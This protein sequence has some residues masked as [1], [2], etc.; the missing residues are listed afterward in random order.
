MS[1]L[2]SCR[3]DSELSKVQEHLR[4]EKAMK[5][6]LYRERDEMSAEK[7]SVEQK[8]KVHVHFKSGAV[9]LW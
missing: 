4:E 8:F 6:K 3:F 2:S 5:E 9:V 7:Y 1:L